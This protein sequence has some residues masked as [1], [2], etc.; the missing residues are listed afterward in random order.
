MARFGATPV[1][2]GPK[3]VSVAKQSNASLSTTNSPKK[4]PSPPVDKRGLIR[5][6][7][8]VGG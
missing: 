6:N 2:R 8:V 3:T 5:G 4:M 1:P 7:L